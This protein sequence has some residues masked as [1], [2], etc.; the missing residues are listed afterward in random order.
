MVKNF[1]KKITCPHYSRYLEI[2][3]YTH[4]PNGDMSAFI[5]GF[6][7]CTECAKRVYFWT[8]KD[9]ILGKWIEE[10]AKDKQWN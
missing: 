10:N 9:S 2:W 5:E 4:G 6:Q 1:F 8:E 7:V 3:H